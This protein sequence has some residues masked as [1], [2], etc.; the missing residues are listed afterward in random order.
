[1]VTKYTD[2]IEEITNKGKV[3]IS[4]HQ[5]Q[6]R[7]PINKSKDGVASDFSLKGDAGKKIL[8]KSDEII[9]VALQYHSF[10]YQYEWKAVLA[11]Y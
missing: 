2:E 5:N 7:F 6:W 4:T 10:M 1:M 9:S 3:G 11:K 8:L